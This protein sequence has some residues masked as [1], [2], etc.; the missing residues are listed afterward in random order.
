VS[1]LPEISSVGFILCSLFLQLCFT[2]FLF[3]VPI[4][5]L[6]SESM[7]SQEDEYDNSLSDLNVHAKPWTPAT[8]SA[9]YSPFAKQQQ[10]Q[11]QS[12]YLPYLQ[13]QYQQQQYHPSTVEQQYLLQSPPPSQQ[14]YQQPIGQYFFNPYNGFVQ[15]N[16]AA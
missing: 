14:H 13:H 16:A 12:T 3:I 9:S 4:T 15:G 2:S 8:A 7:M 10:Q 1:K 11:H 5:Q 6:F